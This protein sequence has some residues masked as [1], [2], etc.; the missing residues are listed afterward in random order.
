MQGSGGWRRWWATATVVAV[1]LAAAA[2]AWSF[3]PWL[4]G[5]RT[6][7]SFQVPA[8]A[9][10][11]PSP[12][13]EAGVAAVDITPAIG[14]PRFDSNGRSPSGDGFQTR[15]H[16]RAFYL[17][18]P[19]QKPLALVQ[20]DLGA[21]ALALQY[22][23]AEKVAAATDI[24]AANLTLLASH[25]H[26]GPGAYFGNDLSNRLATGRPGLDP[27]LFQFL[28]DRI[29]KAVIQAYQNRRPARFA[30]GR[31]RLTGLTRNTNLKAWAANQGGKASQLPPDAARRAINP[32]LT[33]L[34]IDLR[35]DDG[36]FYPAAA[37]AFFSI[38]ADARRPANRAYAA[39]LWYWAGTALKRHIG[40]GGPW[41][42]VTGT[43]QGTDGDN[44]PDWRAGRRGEDAARRL[45]GRL[46]QAMVTLFDQLQSQ[47]TPRLTTA[48][49]SRLVDL[50]QASG[51]HPVLCPHQMLTNGCARTKQ[52]LFG[53]LQ[54][55]LPAGTFP[56][57][58]LLQ[59]LRINDLVIVPL[60]WSVDLAA[61]NALRGAVLE[62]LPA[63]EAWKVA[64]SSEANG[65]LGTL[66]TAREYATLGDHG[67]N[68]LYGPGTL[69]FLVAQNRTLSRDL[70]RDGDGGL[71]A[72]LHFTPLRHRSWPRLSDATRTWPRQWVRQARFE[73]GH[74]DQ[75]AT[76]TWRFRGEPPAALALDQPLLRIE[77]ARTGAVVADDQHGDLGLRLVSRDG[78][79]AVYEVRWSH[80]P[81]VPPGSLQLIVRADD[82]A[83]SLTS[84]VFP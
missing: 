78:D 24:P 10:A 69:E 3:W 27:A 23:V 32:R 38:D 26:S 43:A 2:S 49:T 57:H 15:L 20:L 39:D 59:V 34:R 6:N 71:P 77:N 79:A 53:F 28:V 82:H 54:R 80:P 17:H 29:S 7:L 35:A 47:L 56:R 14:L 16:A 48:S 12:V 76:W 84:S 13:A 41:P 37:L 74:R 42:F 60:P 65:Y 51:D 62:T 52:R 18:G 68:V 45:G 75:P 4:I 70:F 72:S 1:V 55:H 63:S 50:A 58:A 30:V 83:P 44:E 81:V 25:T 22:A 19:D 73:S 5:S 33:L 40:D 66:V 21:G 36:H 46:G 64:I 67:R 11:S 61:G 8:P 31:S 9:S